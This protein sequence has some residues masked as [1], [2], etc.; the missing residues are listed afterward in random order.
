MR[1]VHLRKERWKQN[2]MKQKEMEPKNIKQSNTKP[3]DMKQLNVESKNVDS[4][5]IEYVISAYSDLLYRTGIMLL[6]NRQDAEDAVQEVLIKYMK[7]APAFTDREHE[8][9]WLIRVMINL[10]KDMLRY[11]SRRC[12]V[13]LDEVAERL[14][15]SEKEKSS[16]TYGER[17]ILE[18]MQTLPSNWRIAL[19]L[20]CLE[21]YSEGEIAKILHISQNAVKKRIWR[22]RRALEKRLQEMDQ[23][24]NKNQRE[25]CRD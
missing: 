20:Y 4:Q 2:D 14:P 23:A 1:A 10:C 5:K 18:Q 3:K 24:E 13:S 12:Y 7:K 8:K 19:I 17:T 16:F 9:A 25:N 11:Q 22:G 21:G 6:K 15:Y